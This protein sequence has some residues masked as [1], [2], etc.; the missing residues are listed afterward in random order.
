MLAPN[1]YTVERSALRVLNAG[2]DIGDLTKLSP[3]P[4]LLATVFCWGNASILAGEGATSKTSV[5]IVQYLALATERKLTGE[6]VFKRSRVLFLSFED[7]ERE[8]KRRIGAAIKHYALKDEE[9][10]G[11]LYFVALSRQDGK[12]AVLDAEKQIVPGELAN[13]LAHL[14]IDL[15]SIRKIPRGRGE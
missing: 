5:R 13:N 9:L 2:R 8:M 6:H 1:A 12:V 7:D 15:R 10:D 11:W 4:F 3:R 14:I